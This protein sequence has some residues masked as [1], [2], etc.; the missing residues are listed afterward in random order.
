MPVTWR[1]RRHRKGSRSR[2]LPMISCAKCLPCQ[3]R[4]KYTL[5]K[6]MSTH[7]V[8]ILKGWL[9]CLR[10]CGPACIL[11]LQRLDHM[12]I[13]TLPFVVPLDHKVGETRHHTALRTGPG[14]STRVPGGKH[15]W[16]GVSP[17]DRYASAGAER[18][19]SR[20]IPP[21]AAGRLPCESGTS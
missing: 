5:G 7:V 14:G 12:P 1:G 9:V 8:A 3:R 21:I 20:K 16:E 4:R 6:A 19:P 2:M 13:A 18:E 15:H 11:P 17:P 10:S